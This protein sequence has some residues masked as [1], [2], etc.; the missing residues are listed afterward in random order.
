MRNYFT[1]RSPFGQ[2]SQSLDKIPTRMQPFV[3]TEF[4]DRVV[5]MQDTLYRA[6]TT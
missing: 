1:E 4:T 5:A 6:A 2:R 3:L